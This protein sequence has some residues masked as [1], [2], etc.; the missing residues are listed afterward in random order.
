MS[1]FIWTCS[2]GGLYFNQTYPI[3]PHYA[4]SHDS[5]LIW[6]GWFD[7]T[8]LRAVGMPYA[9]TNTQSMQTDGYTN[10]NNNDH[11]F[12]IGWENASPLLIA[13]AHNGQ[14]TNYWFLYWYFYY[15]LGKWDGYYH[16][17]HQSLDFASGMIYGEDF[18]D[19][20]YWY[21]W[22]NQT[23]GTWTRMRA[24]GNHGPPG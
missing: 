21:G 2:C 12:Y 23:Y 11:G 3:T 14:T 10:Y 1:E 19:S 4:T 20:P 9:W 5:Q 13:T 8:T 18:G 15:A 17:S 24:M 16:N 7:G 6:Y 22:L